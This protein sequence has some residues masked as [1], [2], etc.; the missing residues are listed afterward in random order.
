MGNITQEYAASSN[1]TVT[2][3]HSLPASASFITGWESGAI[4][5]TSNKYLDYVI[6]AQFTMTSTNNQAGEIRIYIVPQLDDSTWPSP[7]DGTESTESITDTEERDAIAIFAKSVAVDASTGAVIVVAPFSV[8]AACGYCPAKFVIFIT[9]NGATSTNAQ[10]A[11][12]G[13]QVTIK[14]TYLAVA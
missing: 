4:D 5:N 10:F 11:A 14:G 6:S 9:G 12:S 2:N 1:V 7:F 3:L 13:N 8:R